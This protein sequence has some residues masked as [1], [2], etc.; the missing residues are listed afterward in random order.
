M[1]YHLATPHCDNTCHHIT[2][3]RANVKGQY[4]FSGGGGT[5]GGFDPNLGRRTVAGVRAMVLNMTF[6]VKNCDEN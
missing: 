5:A 1:P 4:L 6:A 3:I 2:T